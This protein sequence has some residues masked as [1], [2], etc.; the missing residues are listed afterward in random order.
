[1]RPLRSGSCS[2]TPIRNFLEPQIAHRPDTVDLPFLR[3]TR[4]LPYVPV[5][6]LHFRQQI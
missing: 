4:W 2:T 5:L 6:V 1:M 3:T